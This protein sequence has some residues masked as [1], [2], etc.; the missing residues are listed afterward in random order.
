MLRYQG[1]AF[2]L[3]N[4]DCSNHNNY[5]NII[6]GPGKPLFTPMADSPPSGA[7]GLTLFCSD[8]SFG[9]G[10]N[11][12][13][14]YGGHVAIL[15]GPTDFNSC[16]LRAVGT[17]FRGSIPYGSLKQG[18]HLCILYT[19]DELALVTLTSVSPP[20]LYR[21]SGTASVWQVLT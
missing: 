9:N 12:N 11:P 21:V 16:Y 15:S 4:D 20:G 8:N 17:S 10:L 7:F 6:F 5:P 18:I 1:E 13:L 3:N 19:D 14:Q 2:T